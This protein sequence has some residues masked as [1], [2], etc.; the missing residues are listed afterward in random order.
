MA[1]GGTAS[2]CLLTDK[3]EGFFH[4]KLRHRGSPDDAAAL[5]SVSLPSKNPLEHAAAIA[6][7][8]CSIFLLS[9]AIPEAK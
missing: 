2:I 8:S 4:A 6:V 9:P 1:E 3:P 7:T 5:V